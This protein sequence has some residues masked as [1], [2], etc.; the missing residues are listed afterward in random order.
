MV[1]PLPTISTE[2]LVSQR[3]CVSGTIAP[4]TVAYTGGTGTATYQW[5]SNSSDSNTGGN[6]IAGATAANYTPP[7]FNAVGTY[8]FY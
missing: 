1:N 8:Y 5:Y 7:A 4:L 3:I 6:Q 2:P